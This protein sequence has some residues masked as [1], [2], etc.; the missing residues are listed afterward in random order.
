MWIHG[1]DMYRVYLSTPGDLAGELDICRAA[2]SEINSK[3]AMPREI[4]LVSVR[5]ATTSPTPSR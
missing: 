2:I 3:E 5:P 4:L 1:F